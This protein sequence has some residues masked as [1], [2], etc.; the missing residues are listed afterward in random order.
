MRSVLL[1]AALAGACTLDA[2]R[3]FSTL[4]SVE[5]E[6]HFEP[7]E[8]ELEGGV[9]TDLG[10][11]VRLDVITLELAELEL[12]TFDTGAETPTNEHGH[13]HDATC[14]A[15]SE[16]NAEHEE[17]PERA[18]GDI[19][20]SVPVDR[21]VDVLG[22]EQLVLTQVDPSPELGEVHLEQAELHVA[23]IELSGVV[24][25]GGLASELPL[26]VDLT[27]DAHVTAGMDVA[28]THEGPEQLSLHGTLALE[29]ALFD[30]IDFALAED[31]DVNDGDER[32]EAL[33]DA[34]TDALHLSLSPEPHP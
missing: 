13:C 2:G 4:E 7:G 27:L 10:Y 5:L 14:E 24:T 21:S 9:V 12:A 31:F 28:V 18:E 30:G 25:D 1:L 23:R 11:L 29:G 15:E 34:L 33:R 20:V 8:H 17:R 32:A 16:T 22:G 3:G 19:V 6:A 26:S